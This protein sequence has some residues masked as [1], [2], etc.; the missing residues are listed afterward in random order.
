MGCTPSYGIHL[1]LVPELFI[2]YLHQMYAFIPFIILL[3]FFSSPCFALTGTVVKV[4]DGDTVTVLDDHYRQHK[5]RLYGIDTPEKK[6]AF[7]RVAG[8][9]TASLIA[10]Q[11]VDVEEIDRDRYG[12]TVGI[13]RHNGKVVNRE[14]VKAGYAWVYRQYCKIPDCKAWLRDEAEA[15]EQRIGLWQDKE[16][17]PPWVW[18]KKRRNQLGKR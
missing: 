3:C 18:R 17:V 15:R 5:I 7:G 9:A 11:V 6:Q 1:G 4:A 14:L 12:R 10:G 8:R 16:P 13:I 2:L